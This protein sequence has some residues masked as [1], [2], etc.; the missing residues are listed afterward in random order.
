MTIS[1]ALKIIERYNYWQGGADA[2]GNTCVVESYLYAK[3]HYQE[4]KDYLCSWSALEDKIIEADNNPKNVEEFAK[5]IKAFDIM[6]RKNVDIGCFTH[7]FTYVEKDKQLKFY[8][9]NGQYCFE[10][11]H[12][13]LTDEE[14]AL[15][16]EAFM[17]D[18]EIKHHK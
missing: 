2:T 12:N 11:G 16:E 10:D 9:K 6:R 13:D 18:A 4:A 3:K 1:D 14:Y 7:S 17:Y 5:P 15:L 8:N